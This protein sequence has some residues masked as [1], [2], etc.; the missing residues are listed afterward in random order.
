MAGVESKF[1]SGFVKAA[2]R[3]KVMSRRVNIGRLRGVGIGRQS[4]SRR[5][6]SRRVPVAK[7]SGR[8]WVA[9]GDRREDATLPTR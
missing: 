7:P 1:E 6:A 4:D 8:L 9:V 2:N 3:A 5:A